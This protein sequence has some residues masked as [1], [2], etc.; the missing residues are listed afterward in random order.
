MNQ[1][2]NARKVIN[3]VDEEMAKLFE[4]RMKAVEDVVSYKIENNIPVFDA[5]REKELIA[6]NVSFIKEE[7]YKELYL[8]Q[9]SKMLE[10]SKNYQKQI[11]NKDVIGYG[12]CE[13]AF[14]HIATM[15]LFPNYKY[16]AYTTF[17]E[18]VKAVEDGEVAYGVIPF[19][20]SFTGEVGETSDLLRDHNVYIRA[21]YDLKINQNLLG[22]KKATLK[23]VKQVYSHPQGLSQCTLFLKGRD[24]EK[25][26]YPNTA[27]AAQYVAS[28]QDKS[29]AAIAS[30]ETAKIYGLDVIEENINNTSDNTTRFIV[31][32][33]QLSETGNR[34]Q[35]LFTVKNETGM[36]ASAM[37][38]I[39][40]HKFNMKSIKS[41]AIPNQPWSYYFHVEI[42]GSLSDSKAKDMLKALQQHCTDI[43]ILG[44]YER[45]E[46]E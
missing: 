18:V 5:Q 39:A 45:K 26:A 6:K 43:K 14:S 3:T 32:H 21:M 41:R 2:E 36:L 28:M 17:N 44:G 20:N 22:V 40:N 34:F 23:D 4:K 1:L 33:K 8:E 30:K 46:E 9:F 29:K 38:C 12:G 25:V 37:N 11:I 35:M 31:I 7:K 10:V 24:I 15:Q 42:E 27:L 13:G 19:E 16:Q